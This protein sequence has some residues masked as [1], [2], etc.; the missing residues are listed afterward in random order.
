MK[1]KFKKF[2]QTART[3]T[4]GT[5]GPAGFELFSIGE[6]VVSPWSSVPIQTDIS[7]KIAGGYLGKIHLPSS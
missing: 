7:F 2:S 3:P 1:I 6:R 5:S 4:Q